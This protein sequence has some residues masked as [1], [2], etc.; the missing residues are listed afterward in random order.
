VGLADNDHGSGRDGDRS[1]LSHLDRV[2]LCDRDDR[3]PADARDVVATKTELGLGRA[4]DR[5][6]DACGDRLRPQ[7]PE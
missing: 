5:E 7:R 4:G 3:D 1:G 2:Q 6:L